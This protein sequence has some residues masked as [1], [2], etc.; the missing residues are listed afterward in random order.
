MAAREAD[1]DLPPLRIGEHVVEDYRTLRLSLKA[2]PAALIR[3][4]SPSA[5]LSRPIACRR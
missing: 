1:V 5:A 4:T 3:M 2:H